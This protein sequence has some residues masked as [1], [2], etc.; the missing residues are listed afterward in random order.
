MPFQDQYMPYTNFFLCL[1]TFHSIALITHSVTFVNP[2]I[3]ENLLSGAFVGEMAL[4]VD[5]QV[6]LVCILTNMAPKRNTC[7]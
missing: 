5:S 2:A 3:E 6:E 4:F 1:H 7:K